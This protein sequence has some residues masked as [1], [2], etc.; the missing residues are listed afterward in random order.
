[1]Q[2]PLLLQ[3]SALFSQQLLHGATLT[4]NHLS[5]SYSS[6]GGQFKRDQAGQLRNLRLETGQKRSEGTQGEDGSQRDRTI[7]GCLPSC[8]KSLS[9][10]KYGQQ[11]STV[12]WRP[13]Q[14]SYELTR[15]WLQ[16]TEGKRDQGPVPAIAKGEGGE[17]WC[18]SI[19]SEGV[20]LRSTLTPGF[21]L[22][23]STQG[24][25]PGSEKAVGS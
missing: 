5:N 4:L 19:S 15:Q 16:M 10:H 21:F 14:L 3:D 2:T 22:L 24:Q 18:H 7:A 9:G 25:D 13:D 23:S 11:G 1:M 6:K 20:R 12:T 17:C 8:L